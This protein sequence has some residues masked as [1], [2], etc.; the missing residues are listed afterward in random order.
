MYLASRAEPDRE[1]TSSRASSLSTCSERAEPSSVIHRA[2]SSQI[3]LFPA[4]TCLVESASTTSADGPDV[5][6]YTTWGLF[7]NN[8]FDVRGSFCTLSLALDIYYNDMY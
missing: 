2:T 4:L 6:S 1:A 7:A 5:P 3:G 8:M